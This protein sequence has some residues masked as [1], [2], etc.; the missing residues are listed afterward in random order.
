MNP[1][2]S[3]VYFIITV[4]QFSTFTFFFC[5]FFT[6]N[7]IFHLI[8]FSQDRLKISFSITLHPSQL[9][10]SEFHLFNFIIFKF[11]SLYLR[12]WESHW[13]VSIYISLPTYRLRTRN[14]FQWIHSCRITLIVIRNF[15]MPCKK[16]CKPRTQCCIVF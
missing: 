12:L 7:Y 13:I 14:Y 6:F 5:I 11:F 16:P 2:S 15:S 3:T 8:H 10:I 9:P 1:L 4:L